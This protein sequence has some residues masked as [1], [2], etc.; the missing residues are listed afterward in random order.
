MSYALITGASSGLG[1]EFAKLFASKGIPMVITSSKRSEEKIN[2]FSEELKAQF[3]VDVKVCAANLEEP[4]A[5]ESLVSWIDQQNVDISYQVK[6][7]GFG[8]SGHKFQ[9]YDM[10]KCK[11]MLQVNIMALTELLGVYVPRMVARGSGSI[12]NVSSIAAY[13]IPHGLEA[14]YSS[15]KVYVRALSECISDDLRG[16]GVSCTHVAPG[17][18]RTEFFY[19]AGLQNHSKIEKMYMEADEVAA[20]GFQAMMARKD[21]VVPGLI[22][23]A[24]RSLIYLSPSRRLTAKISGSVPS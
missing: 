3:G 9:D 13:I 5:V 1:I 18:T 2:S 10:Q 4:T 7:A 17:T 24:I 8:I 15:S 6:T 14:A 21:V 19:T 12:L 11:D 23:K 20:I 16:T 22:N